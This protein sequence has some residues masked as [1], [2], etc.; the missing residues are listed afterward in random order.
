MMRTLSGERVARP[1]IWLMRQAGRYLPEY[2][3]TRARAGGFLDLC[4]TPELAAEVTLQP[5]RRFGFDAAILFADILL[6]PQALGRSLWFEQG[7]GPRFDPLTTLDEARALAGDEEM[8]ERLSPIFET[9]RLLRRE[10][11]MGTPLIGFAGAPWT[12]ATYVIAGRGK[13]EQAGAKSLRAEAPETFAMLIDRLTS[14]TIAYLIAQIDAGAQV[15]KLFDSWAGALNDDPEAFEKAVVAPTRR[16]AEALRKARPGVPLIA[17]PRGATQAGYEK[18]LDAVAPE[19]MALDE[20]TDRAWATRRVQA[21]AATQGDLDPRLL[22]TGGDALKR[23]TEE[24]LEAYSGGPHIFNLGH[25][26]TPEADPRHVEALV[27][28]VKG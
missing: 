12:V 6:V 16:I 18:V 4:Y 27:R 23:A 20:R 8:L 10:L 1:P 13:D 5:I 2:R 7:E 17:F 24:L 28:L 14:A 21:R 22:V 3:E 26:V 19:A 11:P 25:G 15:V 9:V